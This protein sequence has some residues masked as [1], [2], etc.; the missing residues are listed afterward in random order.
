MKFSEAILYIGLAQSLFAAFALGTRKRVSLPDK[1]LI[2]SLLAFAFKFLILIFHGQ[3]KEFFDMQ[4]SLAL[5]PL[6]FGP[7][8]YL[9]TTYL[10]EG[11]RRFNPMH[12]LHFIPFVSITFI[13]LIFFQDVVDFSD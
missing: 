1:F 4:F 13:Y 9:Y 2:G 3:H 11:K 6:T 7:Y 5:I 12:L 8:L 10:I